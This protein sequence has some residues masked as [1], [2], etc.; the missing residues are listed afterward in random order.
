VR[1]SQPPAHAAASS[2][3][4]LRI[5]ALTLVA[6]EPDGKPVY[7]VADILDPLP[8]CAARLLR[9]ARL[10][11]GLRG[12]VL[13]GDANKCPETYRRVEGLGNYEAFQI[14]TKRRCLG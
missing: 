10:T 8:R 11:A 9:S 12:Y 7:S 14:P 4:Q 13:L 5:I 3:S 2:A 6:S 1:T